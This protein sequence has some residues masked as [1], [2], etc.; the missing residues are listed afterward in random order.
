ML[1]IKGNVPDLIQIYVNELRLKY[2]S[3]EKEVDID[4]IPLK[5]VQRS[6]SSFKIPDVRT[7]ILVVVNSRCPDE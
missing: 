7:S 5:A 1:S 6:V 2:T 4:V 3:N